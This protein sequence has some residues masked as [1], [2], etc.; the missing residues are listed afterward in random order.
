MDSFTA[1]IIIGVVIALVASLIRMKRCD[2]CLKDFENDIISLLDSSNTLITGRLDAENT[3]LELLF[4]DD[5]VKKQVYSTYS[6]ENAQQVSYIMYKSD[7]PKI[8]AL[9][10]YHENLSEKD[11]KL[12]AEEI[13]RTYHPNLFRRGKRRLFN[14]LKIVRDSLADIFSMITGQLFKKSG[15]ALIAEQKKQT[16]RLQKEIVDTIEPAFEPLLEKYIGNLVVVELNDE[17]TVVSL[18]G[19]L[20][21]YSSEFLEILDVV[22]CFPLN[23]DG[24]LADVL[25]PR[26]LASVRGI[27]ERVEAFSF[28]DSFNIKK[29]KKVVF[30]S[31]TSEFL[32]EDK[33]SK[34]KGKNKDTTEIS[35]ISNEASPASATVSET[36]TA[37]A[38][39]TAAKLEGKSDK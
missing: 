10:R 35:N 31:L 4:S 37:A 27:A 2:K 20:K 7:Y 8:K 24:K 15:V 38:A 23:C 18:K 21:D 33:I 13:E 1:T 32:A 30:K 25:L 19:I 5:V 11:K 9:I 29:Y 3:G 39:A 22:L 16:D 17:G 26:R 12:R 28:I 36:A 6:P 34:K 14:I